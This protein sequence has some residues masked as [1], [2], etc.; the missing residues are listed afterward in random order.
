MSAA[1]MRGAQQEKD[2]LKK[3]PASSLVLTFRNVCCGILIFFVEDRR[4]GRALYASRQA[5]LTKD[6]QTGNDS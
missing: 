6:M 1:M 4:K 2:S 5:R 3:N